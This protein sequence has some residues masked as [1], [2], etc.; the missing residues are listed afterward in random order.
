LLQAERQ[1]ELLLWNSNKSPTGSKPLPEGMPTLIIENKRQP[2]KMVILK[3]L[4]LRTSARDKISLAVPRA[5]IILRTI[6]ISPKIMRGVVAT[7][8]RLRSV[9]PQST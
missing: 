9:A 2:F 7:I 3:P 1:D 4:M 8:T 6:E 5:K